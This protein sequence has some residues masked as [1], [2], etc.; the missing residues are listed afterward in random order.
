MRIRRTCK[1]VTFLLMQAQDQ[2]PLPWWERLALTLHMTA[3]DACPRV[4]EQLNLMQRATARWRHYSGEDDAVDAR[5][6]PRQPPGDHSD[7]R[8][9]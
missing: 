2:G 8:S 5:D 6:R 3:C 7:E 1:E 9:D 4:R